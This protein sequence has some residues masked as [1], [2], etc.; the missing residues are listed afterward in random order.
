MLIN[1]FLCPSASDCVFHLVVSSFHCTTKFV[2]GTSSRRGCNSRY[3]TLPLRQPGA[4]RSRD[5]PCRQNS[6]HRV[7]HLRSATSHLTPVACAW[8]ASFDPSCLCIILIALM[9][10][11][12]GHF[13]SPFPPPLPPAGQ[14]A[15][16]AASAGAYP[17]QTGLSAPTASTAA[18]PL[19]PL[20]AC[21]S[22][23]RG[24][25]QAVRCCP[26]QRYPP[27]CTQENP[28]KHH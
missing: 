21:S 12:F 27:L 11:S 15:P 1:S 7:S 13:F 16:A 26:G 24:G 9:H 8:M 23:R 22:R 5:A 14:P 18:A 3:Q 17:P 25:S 4:K 19:P 6:P 10:C 28:N 2:V 20:T